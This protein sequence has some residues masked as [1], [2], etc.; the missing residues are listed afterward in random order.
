MEIDIT[1]GLVQSWLV[2][3]DLNIFAQ[4]AKTIMRC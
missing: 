1:L 3:A 2:L 4:E